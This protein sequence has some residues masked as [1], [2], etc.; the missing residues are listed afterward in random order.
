MS[1]VFGY[2]KDDKIYKAPNEIVE[3]IVSQTY[4]GRIFLFEDDSD[5]EALWGLP[6]EIEPEE[7]TK[8]EEELMQAETLSEETVDIGFYNGQR[9][10]SFDNLNDLIN[11]DQV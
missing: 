6:I 11:P 2:E 1:I 5:A 3:Q 9:M 10:F 7:I 8:M 4:D